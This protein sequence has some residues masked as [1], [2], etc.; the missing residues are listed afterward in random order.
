MHLEHGSGDDLRPQHVKG[1][2]VHHHGGM[3]ARESA[4]LKQQDLAAG[5]A[6][7]FGRRADD[8]DGEAH[9][10]RHFGRSQRCANGRGGDDIVAAGVAD[11]R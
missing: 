11:P 4:A 7:F 9:V 1:R 10:V 5:I 8:A 2:G 3:N 6:H